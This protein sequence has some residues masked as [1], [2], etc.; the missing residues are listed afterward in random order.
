[1]KLDRLTQKSQD[2]LEAAQG[3]AL[4]AGHPEISPE[5]L[6]VAL[7][8]QQDGIAP[9]LVAKSGADVDA[10]LEAARRALEKHPTTKGGSEPAISR[11]L[12]KVIEDAEKVA[13]D[14]KDDYVST[15]HLL[16]AILGEKSGPAYE[17]LEEAGVDREKVAAALEAVRGAARV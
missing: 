6:L 5:H 8:E 14:R 12:K 16:L 9:S 11:R 1:M 7:L 15:E 3:R 2:A 13:K 10:A 4:S 17:A